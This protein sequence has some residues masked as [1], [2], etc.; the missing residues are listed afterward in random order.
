MGEHGCRSR[1]AAGAGGDRG[2]LVWSLEVR[3][4]EGDEGSCRLLVSGPQRLGATFICRRAHAGASRL[5]AWRVL[6]GGGSL[7]TGSSRL[8][9]ALPNERGRRGGGPDGGR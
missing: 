5:S 7:Q 4:A 1:R 9:A 3:A 2:V 6:C 8:R